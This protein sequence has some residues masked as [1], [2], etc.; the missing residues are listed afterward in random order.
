[1]DKQEL[2]LPEGAIRN[3]GSFPLDVSLHADLVTRLT[4]AVVAE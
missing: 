2:S 4:V 3:V 1:M